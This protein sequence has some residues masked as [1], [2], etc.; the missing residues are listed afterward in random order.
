MFLSDCLGVNAAGHLTIGG[1]DTIDLA[2]QYGTP[3]YMMDEAQ[4]RQGCRAY[5]EAIDKYYGGR[6]L[7]L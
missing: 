5:K 2:A 3:L 7:P 1:C 4:L 6:G